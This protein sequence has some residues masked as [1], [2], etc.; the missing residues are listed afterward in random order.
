MCCLSLQASSG[1]SLRAARIQEKELT[2]EDVTGMFLLLGAG[3]GIAAFVLFVET[4]LWII[5]K[6]KKKLFPGEKCDQ[7]PPDLEKCGD[8]GNEAENNEQHE[9]LVHDYTPQPGFQK[10]RAYSTDAIFKIYEDTDE[11]SH[12]RLQ[13]FIPV[14]SMTSLSVTS[15]PKL[16]SRRLQ[17]PGPND[18]LILEKDAE[19]SGVETP[20]DKS[21]N[22]YGKYEADGSWRPEFHIEKASDKYFGAKVQEQSDHMLEEAASSHLGL[23]EW[24]DVHSGQYPTEQEEDMHTMSE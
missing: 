8:M 2:L 15:Y 11:T 18:T 23:R 17:T 20:E 1:P 16:E 13:F 19:M 10:R 14:H 7:A 3:F 12:D 9:K 22:G 5:N 4:T 24:K 6:I 21:Y